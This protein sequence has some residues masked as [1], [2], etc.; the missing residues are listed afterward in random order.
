[1]ARVIEHA[2]TDRERPLAKPTRGRHRRP[3]AAHHSRRHRSRRGGRAPPARHA[4]REATATS[5]GGSS[6]CSSRATRKRLIRNFRSH[7]I[8]APR[9]DAAEGELGNVTS[10]F[11][12]D[13]TPDPTRRRGA[14]ARRRSARRVGTAELRARIR[15]RPE[16]KEALERCWPVLSGAELVNDLFGFT[17][18]VRFGRDAIS[19]RDEEQAMLHRRRDRDVAR[20][21]VDRSRRRAHRRSRRAARSGRSR[22]SR[23][24]G[25]AG[26]ATTR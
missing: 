7:Q 26:P 3:P 20:G 19:S 8:D 5:R 18:L 25:A 11:D 1:M 13:L 24:G 22:A 14:R 4:Q 17:A 9:R 6:T 12:R 15:S 10:I 16:V 23:G 2:V 21:A